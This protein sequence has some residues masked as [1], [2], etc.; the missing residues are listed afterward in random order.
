M[1]VLQRC[2]LDWGF[3]VFAVWVCSG[4]WENS[5]AWCV[6]HVFTDNIEFLEFV[7]R[8]TASGKI[9]FEVRRP[10]GQESAPPHA[11]DGLSPGG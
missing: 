4:G 3:P 9:L 2:L 10:P 5:A 6:T 7:I 8:D 1:N 11:L